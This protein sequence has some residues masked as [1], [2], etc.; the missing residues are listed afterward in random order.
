MATIILREKYECSDDC[1]SFGCPKHEMILSFQTV[2]NSY[3]LE[4]GKGET[5]YFEHGELSAFISLLKQLSERRSDA[6]F[7]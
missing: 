7:V 6:V 1:N 2:S 3:R 5:Y 4:N